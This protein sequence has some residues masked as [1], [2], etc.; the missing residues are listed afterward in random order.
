ML[1]HQLA[2]FVLESLPR[3]R[4]V[5]QRSRSCGRSGSPRARARA[6]E[7]PSRPLF[8]TSWPTASTTPCVHQVWTEPADEGDDQ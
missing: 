3:R 6:G 2:R 5:D 8:L 4:A 1:R 7:A